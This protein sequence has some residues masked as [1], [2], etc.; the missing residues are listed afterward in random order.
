MAGQMRWSRSTPCRRYT[1]DPTAHG[2]HLWLPSRPPLSRQTANGHT[3]KYITVCRS[4]TCCFDRIV[5]SVRL[6]KVGQCA[7]KPV[8]LVL[9]R[10][11]HKRNPLPHHGRLGE[12]RRLRSPAPDRYMR[13]GRTGRSLAGSLRLGRCPRRQLSDSS[14]GD[15]CRAKLRPLGNINCSSSIDLPGGA[16]AEPAGAHHEAAPTRRFAAATRLVVEPLEFGGAGCHRSTIQPAGPATL[17]L[18]GRPAALRVR[19]FVRSPLGVVRSRCECRLGCRARTSTLP[20][21]PR[22]IGT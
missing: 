3:A 21:P 22:S 2:V 8:G 1:A 13:M 6:D 17:R 19:D 16:V 12:L 15:R 20:L 18:L 14:L 7:A 10:V 11:G 4:R 5:P 9:S